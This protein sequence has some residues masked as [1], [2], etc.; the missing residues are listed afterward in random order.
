MLKKD[1][2]LTVHA[3]P[4]GHA[5]QDSTAMSS[6]VASMVHAK[7]YQTVLAEQTV[8][9][10]LDTIAMNSKDALPEQMRLFFNDY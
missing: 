9:A 10:P 8:H 4:T 5:P 1:Q 2:S 7:K 3:V 6:S